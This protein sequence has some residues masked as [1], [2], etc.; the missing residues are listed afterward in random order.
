MQ[1]LKENKMLYSIYSPDK[2]LKKQIKENMWK[3]LQSPFIFIRVAWQ[4][5]NSLGVLNEMVSLSL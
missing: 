2:C 4:K 1:K 3:Y 5:Q